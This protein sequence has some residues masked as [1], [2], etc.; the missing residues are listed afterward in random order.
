MLIRSLL[1][2][3]SSHQPISEEKRYQKL[4]CFIT[5]RIQFL[6]QW[7]VKRSSVI[8][9]RICRVSRVSCLTGNE[10][11]THSAFVFSAGMLVFRHLQ[12]L[13]SQARSSLWRLVM[14]LFLIF[15][16]PTVGDGKRISLLAWRHAAMWVGENR[17]YM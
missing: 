17:M 4:N 5:P 13:P 7:A 8:A 6:L 3:S 16:E 11:T 9:Y 15:T 12:K 10:W 1:I 14:T 2:F